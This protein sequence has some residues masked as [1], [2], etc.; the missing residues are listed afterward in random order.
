MH[1]FAVRFLKQTYQIFIGSIT[2]CHC[3]VIFYII[4]R[5]S[6]RRLKTWI[7]PNRITPQILNVIQFFNN[8]FVIIITLPF[9][10]YICSPIT[11]DVLFVYIGQYYICL[12]F[13]SLILILHNKFYKCFYYFLCLQWLCKMFIHS[14]RKRFLTIIYKRLGGH[15]NDR[16]CHGIFPLQCTNARSCL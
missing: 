14:S 4:A 11:A 9:L 10:L 5:I 12:D 8:T 6:K 15:C 16:N 2:R 7:D 3:I 1:I 13:F